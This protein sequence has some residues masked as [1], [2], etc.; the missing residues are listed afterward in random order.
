MKKMKIILAILLI[1]TVSINSIVGQTKILSIEA[2]LFYN[3]NKDLTVVS[4]AAGNV[5][6]NII[7]S[8]FA[9]WNT[10]IGEGDAIGCSNQT[11]V[12]VT[13]QSNGLSNKDQI[14]KLTAT[15]GKKTILQ[16]QKTFSVIGDEV[17]YK[18][19]FL[20]DDT[21]CEIIRLKASVLK[22]GMVVSK[23]EKSINFHC[24]E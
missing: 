5:S 4:D 3:Q 12:V 22:K 14:V 13:V 6:E 21:G 18:I 11:M 19:L 10:I 15:S 17:P 20:L 23:M 9:L 7:D 1:S 2:K 16:Q 24:G 8:K